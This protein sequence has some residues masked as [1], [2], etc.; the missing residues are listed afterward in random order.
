MSGS[1]SESPFAPEH[2]P[3]RPYP[4]KPLR[5]NPLVAAVALRML[6]LR[7]RG[8]EKL[9]FTATTGRSGTLS[10]TRLFAAIP[11]CRAEHEAHPVMNGPVLRAASYGDSDL[12]HRVYSRIKSVNI[13]RAAVGHRYYFEANHLF[14]KTFADMVIADFGRRVAVVHLVR[15]AAEVANSIY[16]LRDYPGTERGNYWWLD[17]RAPRNLLAMT[18]ILES[19]PEFSHPFY[20]ALWYWHE[21]EARIAAWRARTP[22]VRVIDFETDWLNDRSRVYSLLDGLGM[23]YETAQ[24]APLIG[25]REH[26]KT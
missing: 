4:F 16:Q 9:I 11:G 10:L 15:P 14:V 25:A 13:R 18:D 3:M 7:T 24:L 6:Q 8:L 20:K 23:Q 21:V 12:V 2:W 26:A 5:H 17:F 1:G 22:S 19:D